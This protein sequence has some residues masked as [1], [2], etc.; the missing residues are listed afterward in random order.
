MEAGL[1]DSCVSLVFI[2]YTLLKNTYKH[3][4]NTILNH[5]T[6]GT[7]VS[8]QISN[9]SDIERFR[10]VFV[11]GHSTNKNLE[12]HLTAFFDMVVFD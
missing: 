8:R 9:C 11:N 1:W 10:V 2:I 12:V 4:D 3:V 5:L 6:S 7:G